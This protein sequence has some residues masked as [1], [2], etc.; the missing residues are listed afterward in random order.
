MDL[1]LKISLNYDNFWRWRLQGQA[2]M[3]HPRLIKVSGI[4]GCKPEDVETPTETNY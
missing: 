3:T 2:Q 4:L 1:T